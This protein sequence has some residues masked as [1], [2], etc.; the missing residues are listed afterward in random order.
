MTFCFGAEAR[1]SDARGGGGGEFGDFGGC[2]LKL[3]R[4]PR[5]GEGG[6]RDRARAL[7]SGPV[8]ERVSKH[9]KRRAV[10]VGELE[11]SFA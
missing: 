11:Q 3:S 5:C 1:G 8:T 10:L 4:G 9:A 7:N 2:R 6:R